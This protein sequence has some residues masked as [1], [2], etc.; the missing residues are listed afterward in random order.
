MKW[1][2]Q[3]IIISAASNLAISA[4]AQGTFNPK[5]NEAGSVADGMMHEQRADQINDPMKASDI[6]GMTVQNYQH[7]KLGKVQDFA[8]DM[9]SG[10]IV[11]V[12]L[13]TGGFLRLG[14]T[15]T[16]VP[17]QALYHDVGRKILYLNAS[18]EKFN[19]APRFDFTK[20]NEEIQSNQ[21]A[22]IY[23][24][25][26]AQSYF[27]ADR[28]GRWTNKLEG[29]IGTRFS[30]NMDGTINT[31]GARM[32][33]AAH[34]IAESSN[35]ILTRIPDGTWTEGNSWKENATNSWWSDLSY[36]ENTSRLIG[37]PV[38]NSQDEKTGKIENFM[39]NLSSGRIVAV[40]ISSGGYVGI[41]VELK[42]VPPTALRFSVEHDAIEFEDSNGIL[43]GSPPAK[44][45]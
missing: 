30:L 18:Q 28:G 45:D 6:I 29:E 32:A 42:A 22:V 17:P 9:E 11:E 12:I 43:A 14:T 10:R 7:E 39:V 13:S 2:N 38:K 1:Q 31:S 15:F 33:D 4:L 25:Y 36:I 26:G 41:G 3:I 24:Y 34:N 37:T 23:D 27:A 19:A 21:V 44:A 35:A 20:W 40:I 16:A 5:V 8:V